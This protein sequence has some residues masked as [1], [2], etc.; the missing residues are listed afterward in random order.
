MKNAISLKIT[1]N[2]WPVWT[3]D[4]MDYYFILLLCA[5]LCCFKKKKKTVFS[6]APLYLNLEFHP[7]R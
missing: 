2:N 7:K 5:C 6:T 1:L 4:E 3:K